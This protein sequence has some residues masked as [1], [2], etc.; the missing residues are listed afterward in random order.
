MQVE[1]LVA[2]AEDDVA[3]NE[4]IQI[5]DEA[6]TEVERLKHAVDPGQP[7]S[8]QIEEHRKTHLPFRLW[9]KWCIL[10]RGRG[11]QHRKSEGSRIPIIGLD[12]FF[13]TIRG[14]Q[15][16]EELG[17][18]S[19]PEGEK[20]LEEAR[21]KG[22]IVKCL[23]VRCSV[24]KI[25]MGFVVPR[26][27]AD[28]NDF[29]A[30][31]VAHAVAWLGHTK[32]I[33]KADGEPAIQSLVK[34]VL[35]IVKVECKDLEQ[36]SKENPAAYDSQS[37]GGIEQG[38]R[39][40]RGIF[41]SLK[42]CL[43]E[44]IDKF[45]PID[46]PVVHWL[47]EHACLLLNVSVRGEDGLT[48]WAR[49]RGRAFGQQLV[50]FGERVLYKHPSKGPQHA[51]QGNM[52]ATGGEGVFLGFSRRS[53]T[54]LVITEN[55]L[56]EARSITR[57]PEQDRW[58]AEDLARIQQTP[59]T[60]HTR[61]D[62]PRV[63]F[64]QPAQEQGPT[65]EGVRPAQVR[66]LRIN[67][68]DLD[69]YGYEESC[70]QCR[71][72]IRYGKARPGA[73]HSD[74]CRAKI[75]EAMSRTDV[76]RARL[77]EQETRETRAVSD[78]VEHAEQQA[79]QGEPRAPADT[80]AQVPRGF[81]ERTEDGRNAGMQPPA[82][83]RVAR[84]SDDSA[85][86]TARP[87]AVRFQEEISTEWVP[88]PGGEAAPVTPRGT[89][90]VTDDSGG[91]E[92][93]RG[94]SAAV[95]EVGDEAMGDE[96]RSE[97]YDVDM[98]FIGNLE[99]HDHL[100]SI[101]PTVDDFVSGLL[102]QQ[103]GS[104]GRSYKR[105]ARK[106]SKAL[107]SEIYSPP[108]VT[109]LLR[110]CRSRHVLPGFA[111]DITVNDPH[112]DK[113]WDFSI[114]SKRARA[115]RLIREQGPYV[116]I[117][118]PM[119][120]HFSA[121]QALNH[122][123]S[124]DKERI[125]RERKE[126]EIHIEFVAC[127]YE[128]QLDAGRYFLH[129]HPLCATSWAMPR[130]Q[131]ILA[132]AEVQRVRGDQCQFGAQI[133]DGE[134][135]GDPIMKPSGFMTNSP[136]IAEALTVRCQGA[137]GMCS[138]PQGGQHRVCSGRHAK[139][140]AI[141]PKSL[142]RAIIKGVRDQ[143][144]RD[145]QIKDGCF[146][147]QA[148]DED[149]EVERNL[150][151]PAQGYSGRFRDDLTG[152]V[153]KDELVREARAK[154]LEYFH[155]K[156]VWIKVSKQSVRQR[157]GRPP[158]SVRW[159]DVNKGDDL[160]PKYRSRLVARQLKALDSSGTSYFAPA[161]PL[162]ALRVVLSMAMTRVGDWQPVWDPHSPQRTQISLVDVKRAYFNAKIDPR[163][164]PTH[165]QLPAEDPDAADMC[166]RLLRHMYGTRS[167]ADGWQEEYS[168]LL[169]SLG[170][171][172]G[173]ACPNVFRHAERKIV[174]SVHGDDFTSCGSKP[175]LD[176]LE[177]AIKE[178]YELDIG[179][180]MGPG[181]QDAKEGR[182]LNRV[183]RWGDGR[184]EYEAD[185]RQ[186]E[187]LVAECG[188]EGAKPVATPG[189]KPTFHA[190]E[191]DKELPGHLVT[192]FRGAA[193]RGNYLAADRLDV[194][195]ACKEVCRWMAKP[196][197][198]AW[199]ALKR[200][201]RYLCRAPRLV[202]E[203]RQQ[204]VSTVDVYTDT[205]W[206]GCPKTRKSTSGGCVMLGHHACKH[207]SSTQQ[208]I[209]LS[210]GEAEF[211]GVI[212]GAGQGLGFQA[213]LRDLGLEVPL[214]VW[215]DSS[216]AIGICSRQGLG[217]LRHLDT[218]TLWV[219]QAVRTKRIDLRK[220]PGE[221]NPAD[222]LT[223]HSISRQR[224]EDLVSLYSCR[225]LGGRAESAPQVKKGESGRLTMADAG[226]DLVGT[227]GNQEEEE[228]EEEEEEPETS[229]LMPHTA[230]DQDTLDRLYP[231]L[232]A[233]EDEAL[234]DLHSDAGDALFQHGLKIAGEIQRQTAAQGRRRR[235]QQSE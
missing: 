188:L 136:A 181:P 112:D 81:L 92:D 83:A 128:D 64:E 227:A 12:Y 117:G 138:R 47:L 5:K 154:E 182:V 189:V 4:E 224:L 232:E 217:K 36:A 19:S 196:T 13:I 214:R 107:V 177:E 105:E 180:R 226:G 184:L 46:H 175:S 48:A 11:F 74:R 24:S 174:M 164:P 148:P 58:R 206:A 27:G 45:I 53:N 101:E 158:I 75:V 106:S 10:G 166:A 147:V 16:R 37:N 33:L 59:E 211:A 230:V 198:H 133:R 153:L 205:D 51:P 57:R 38:I 35:E 123:K 100:G 114:P 124:N 121:W 86:A 9:C 98:D 118:S 31:K 202:Y 225:Y 102:L 61:A 93:T 44:R 167:A 150:R 14:M 63:H 132:R 104:L 49:V 176:W 160:N 201:C 178:H 219:Q 87:Q 156:S 20:Q 185:P 140:A 212:R 17:Y 152:Q 72:I 62:R 56:V 84:P 54:Y 145:G 22:E 18:E 50:G 109:Q 66:R 203:Y 162:E 139:Q 204:S 120:T 30:D 115:R 8:K 200:V 208:S 151:G 137:H 67:K 213:L 193:A 179:P 23:L 187:R 143:L 76:G 157:G 220:V 169:V 89:P 228:E 233:P 71:Y 96:D 209:S 207:W 235:P 190:L 216:A 90:P 82:G 125:E 155:S 21:A 97:E 119:C 171:K 77:A 126:A 127:L 130:M 6:D 183:I 231:P 26:K 142:C 113:P 234:E 221:Q 95:P 28:E 141:Y 69:K 222:L 194:Q 73:S 210:S 129:E 229:A 70:A 88:V 78:Q 108:R 55:G 7:T 218:H 32:V 99:A 94:D 116:L 144:R 173:N 191:E 15:K 161:P 39:L 68:T 60:L 43:E 146:G 85:Q 192:A 131:A 215:T 40:V 1:S 163:D 165:V 135:R 186:I 103:L 159:V 25:L 29:V 3:D 2:P 149:A 197:V 195:F 199:E 34:R 223:K 91:A 134:F 80:P 168:T 111:F 41:R 42:L 110:H 52:G 172:Q 122:A 79:R 65:T 170:F